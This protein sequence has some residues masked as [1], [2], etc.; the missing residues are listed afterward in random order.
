MN[1]DVNS[2]DGLKDMTDKIRYIYLISIASFLAAVGEVSG[3]AE[4]GGTTTLEWQSTNDKIGLTQE[5]FSE[6][7]GKARDSSKTTLP[8][9]Q[10]VRSKWFQA[11][12]FRDAPYYFAKSD[13]C[14]RGFGKE[15]QFGRSQLGQF[16]GTKA[17]R[18]HDFVCLLVI[19]SNMGTRLISTAEKNLE[20]APPSKADKLKRAVDKAWESVKILAIKQISCPSGMRPVKSNIGIAIVEDGFDGA[21]ILCESDVL[22]DELVC[23]AGGKMVFDGQHIECRK[24]QACFV[25]ELEVSSKKFPKLSRFLGSYRFCLTCIQ[26]SFDERETLAS[27]K[28]DFLPRFIKQEDALCRKDAH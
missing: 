9:F 7:V 11:D 27:L 1:V 22:R 15:S 25:E 21:S 4:P 12:E 13:Y 28:K 20:N 18:D 10:D 5:T 19:A 23:P 16:A 3:L 8:K 26:G 6:M 14:E 2:Y 24:E 17:N